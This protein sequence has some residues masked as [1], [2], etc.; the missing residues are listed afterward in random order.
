MGIPEGFPEEV[1]KDSLRIPFKDFLKDSLRDFLKY[2]LKDFL[3][4]VLIR[5]SL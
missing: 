1:L 3:K 5:I 4:D 2:S